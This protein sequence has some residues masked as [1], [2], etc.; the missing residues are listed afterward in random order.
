MQQGTRAATASLEWPTRSGRRRRFK[1]E[2]FLVHGGC[3]PI[4]AA[5]RG[6]KRRRG[7][8]TD[9]PERGR[10]W[11]APRAWAAEATPFHG[12]SRGLHRSPL[13]GN[14][15]LRPNNNIRG[16][17]RQQC[18]SSAPPL[19]LRI[20]GISTRAST[21]TRTNRKR[22]FRTCFNTGRMT[23]TMKFPKGCTMHRSA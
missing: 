2:F 16:R 9:D 12:G 1:F 14:L 10:R 3:R 4:W 17:W 21:P 23:S 7:R 22:Y 6:G 8:C 18:G 13:A 11:S 20:F 15:P 5:A 19:P